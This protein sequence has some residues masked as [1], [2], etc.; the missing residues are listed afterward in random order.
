MALR[1]TISEVDSDFSQK[2]QNFPTLCVPLL[3]GSPLEFGIST[4]QKKT[5][6]LGYMMVNKVLK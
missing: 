4:G 6:W 3:M 1:H 2:L 5:E